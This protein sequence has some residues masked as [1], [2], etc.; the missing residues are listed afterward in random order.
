MNV[1]SILLAFLAQAVLSLPLFAADPILLNCIET[2]GVY[3]L[4]ARPKTF[5]SSNN[6]RR[7]PGSLSS[8]TGELINIVGRVTDVN[9]LPIQ[10]AVVSIWHAN[11]CGVNHYDENMEG[12]QLDPNFAGSGRFIV[13]NLGYYNFITVAP[14][15]IGDR[16]PH[17][18]FL[19]Q[20][21]DFPEFATQ[22]FF[23][24][25]NCDNC[26]DSVLGSFIDSGLASLLIAPF[27]YNNRAIK[28][29]TFNI[30]LSGCNKF[31]GKK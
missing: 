16:A 5:N 27:A 23:A 1:R 28:T 26:A 29:Y 3:D 24:D 31:S 11:S 17:V 22:M 15:K 2:P 13:N 7:K 30:T 25:H 8:A 12:N 21:P 4:D 19:V 9:C 18:N 10:N 14:G 6:L 20:H